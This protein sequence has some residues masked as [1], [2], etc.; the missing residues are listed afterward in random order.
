M[1]PKSKFL[2]FAVMSVFTFGVNATD[3]EQATTMSE[4]VKVLHEQDKANRPSR[5]DLS[6]MSDEE[7]L[8]Q[9]T[10]RAGDTVIDI[11]V[12]ALSALE[13]LQKKAV[14][15]AVNAVRNRD[16]RQKTAIPEI[17]QGVEPSSDVALPGASET[18]TRPAGGAKPTSGTRN[19]TE[20]AGGRMVAFALILVVAASVFYGI[21]YGRV[22]FGNM[23]VYSSW[24]DFA[25]S[26]A[27]VVLF[28]VGAGCR[29]AA[30]D[31]NDSIMTLG[32][33]FVW[34][35]GGSAIWMIGGAF[36]NKSVTDVLL[37]IPARIIV[38]VLVL[39]AW[40]KLKESLDGMRDH[41]KGIVDGVLIPLGLALFVF[42]AL[43]KP[44][45]GDKRC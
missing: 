2:L 29:Y 3:I 9:A 37:A 27:W 38:A 1:F 28:I 43:V 42:N 24:G 13:R 6:E 15:A 14:G 8:A 34:C 36:Q 40:S 17:R 10:E 44:M 39:F 21:A 35:G 18:A 45:I 33:I 5:K 12:G 26:A 30:E 4:L 31:S 41:R 19:A 22:K 20:E 25:A 23:V 32:T 7:V 16:A 11:G